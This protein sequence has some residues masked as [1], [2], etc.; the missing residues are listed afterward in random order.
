MVTNKAGE[1][2]STRKALVGVRLRS[3]STEQWGWNLSAC[4]LRMEC[5]VAVG[6]PPSV[7]MRRF[8]EE[9]SRLRAE[10]DGHINALAAA[11]LE[12]DDALMRAP[13]P[14]SARAF[15]SEESLRGACSR[16]SRAA[17]YRT[18]RSKP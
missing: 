11:E 17:R 18:A 15:A 5:V 12:F 2:P 6:I 16:V 8:R 10:S 14:V 13:N 9:V 3:G 7:S 4:H 1:K